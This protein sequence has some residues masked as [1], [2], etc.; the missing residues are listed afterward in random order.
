MRPARTVLGACI[1]IDVAFVCGQTP[2]GSAPLS[3]GGMQSNLGP[4]SPGGL[5]SNLGTL[6][7]G[8]LQSNL[9]A[10]S[11]GGLQSNLG[12]LSPGGTPPQAASGFSGLGDMLGGTAQAAPSMPTGFPS[13]GPTGLPTGGLLGGAAPQGGSP[14]ASG[15]QLPTLN[16][17]G[18]AMGAQGGSSTPQNIQQ[19]Q[20]Q[21]SQSPTLDT[22]CPG[23]QR[24]TTNVG[25]EC[26]VTIWRTGGCK[27]ENAPKYEEWHQTQSLEV[28]VSDVVQWA[29]LPDERHKQ[30]CYGGA[31]PPQN[32]PA[33]P[34]P[35]R[36]GL[37]PPSG[38]LLG[39]GLLQGGGQLQGGGPLQAGGPLSPNS[40]PPP[41]VAQKIMAILQSPDV[42][43]L[44][45][46][47]GRQSPAV[48]D[49]CWKKIWRQ[50]GCLEA[51]TP[52]YEDWHNAQSFE[53]LVADAAQWA[54]LSSAKHRQ[55]CYGAS[56]EL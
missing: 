39:G 23:K 38:G 37:A 21:A 30:G 36:A 27:V 19:M 7:P 40:G 5:Q 4:L 8:G 47:V 26:W 54:S 49:A 53:V 35:T 56:A 6:S 52:A 16:L 14:I 50:V 51:T 2:F 32:E 12:A 22:M 33:P 15:I 41:E 13:S 10:L 24:S 28:L 1:S 3:P 55:T 18:G 48:G 20:A 34:Q 43:N 17:M 29:N 45:P 25:E 46:G 44:C 9:G 42:A 11:P 31:G